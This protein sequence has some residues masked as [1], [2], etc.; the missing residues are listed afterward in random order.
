MYAIN[1]S[2]VFPVRAYTVRT[3]G[4]L[5]TPWMWHWCVQYR[6]T[7]VCYIHLPVC[8]L[9]CVRTNNYSVRM[10]SLRTG[11]RTYAVLNI[12]E[13]SDMSCTRISNKASRVLNYRWV[14]I[15]SRWVL[16]E[17]HDP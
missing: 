10:A 2:L 3:Y 13:A 8:V 12:R 9:G 7:H 4:Q 5:N 16:I 17:S 11:L 1:Y 15:E 14:L 6:C